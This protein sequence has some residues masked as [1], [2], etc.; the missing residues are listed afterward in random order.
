MSLPVRI[1]HTRQAPTAALVWIA[2]V[3]GMSISSCS[4]MQ[5][6]SDRI[7]AALR[8][9]DSVAIASLLKEEHDLNLPSKDGSYPLVVAIEWGDLAIVRSLLDAGADSNL[10]LG[11]GISPFTLSIEYKRP[12][13][14]VM[15]IDRGADCVSGG[16]IGLTP[17][18][19]AASHGDVQLVQ[20]LVSCG[21]QVDARD[22]NGWTALHTAAANSADVD[23]ARALVSAGANV[24]AVGGGVTPIVLAIGGKRQELSRLLINS[25]ADLTIRTSN[26]ASV[27]QVAEATHD[28]ALIK[29]VADAVSVRGK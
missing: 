4:G 25:G 16:S 26:G 1:V 2:L 29:L 11:D 28:A 9:H 12:D 22:A 15:L 3:I 14:A 24:N 6:T 10:K 23:I 8:A 27:L 17:L 13:I 7:V 20:K 21:A 18:H 19:L 5:G